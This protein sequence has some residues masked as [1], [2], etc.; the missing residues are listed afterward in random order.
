MVRL[1]GLLGADDPGDIAQEAFIRLRGKRSQLRKV[2]VSTFAAGWPGSGVRLWTAGVPVSGSIS[3][4]QKAV[5]AT[6]YDAAGHVLGQVQ[7]SQSP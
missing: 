7:L 1:A 4:L 5:T 6:A 2:S 3:D